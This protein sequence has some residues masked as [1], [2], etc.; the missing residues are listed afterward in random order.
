MRFRLLFLSAL[1]A[2]LAAAGLALRFAGRAGASETAR[3]EILQRRARLQTQ[4]ENAAQMLA[5]SQRSDAELQA[6]RAR[7]ASLRAPKP[8][9]SAP[10]DDVQPLFLKEVLARD[11]NLQRMHL[12]N[13]RRSAQRRYGRFFSALGLS[14]GEIAR[15]IEAIVGHGEARFDLD[16]VAR[17][18]R[19]GDSDP[20]IAALRRK[21]DAALETTQREIL[22][23]E[24]YR[25]LQE[26]ESKQAVRALVNDLSGKAALGGIP[27][28]EAQGAQLVQALADA[29]TS[30]RTGKAADS[31]WL[32]VQATGDPLWRGPLPDNFDWAFARQRARAILTEQQFACFEQQIAF[33]EIPQLINMVVNAKSS[34]PGRN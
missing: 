21:A 16:G 31:P 2:A 25:A 13:E 6:E 29:N 5:A 33:Y 18:Q 3:Q 19:L 4:I 30:Y 28:T 12:E 9:E 15:L 32:A 20:A 10:T 26:H 8:A 22:G 17:T 1:I 11:A 34:A 14:A 24:R 23:D 27:L 7:A